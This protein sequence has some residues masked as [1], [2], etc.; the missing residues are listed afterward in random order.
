MW[1]LRE[2]EEKKM[3]NRYMRL[4]KRKQLF[5][6]RKKKKIRSYDNSIYITFTKPRALMSCDIAN[7]RLFGLQRKVMEERERER[8]GGG[9]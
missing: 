8:K 7:S 6:K 5:E 9:I 1:G 2:E 4:K 3:G